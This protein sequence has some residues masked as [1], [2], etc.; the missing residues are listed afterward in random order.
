MSPDPV[1]E[2][3]QRPTPLLAGCALHQTSFARAVYAPVELEPQEGQPT[4]HPGMETAEL[5]PPC[6]LRRHLQ[7][8]LRPPFRQHPV[9]GF[10]LPLMLEGAYEVIRLA[11]EHRLAPAVGLDPLL[12]P[13]V[14]PRVQ[15][16][17][18]QNRRNP[19]PWRCPGLRMYKMSTRFQYPS[20]EPLPDEP[21]EGLVGEALTPHPLEPVMVEAV[22]ESSTIR[23]NPLS[24]TS[25]LQIE[26]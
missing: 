22:E 12:E 2:R 16:E 26:T 7:G 9:E 15:R 20:P 13:P 5:P 3:L 1:A 11:D 10:G 19:S 24:E 14:Q 17:V 8:E 25:L 21:Q 6:L 18:R 4:P 23:L